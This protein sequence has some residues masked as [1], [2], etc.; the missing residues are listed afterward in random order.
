MPQK[1]CGFVK[2]SEARNQAIEID[3]KEK[4][5]D[6]FTKG[7]YHPQFEYPRQTLMGW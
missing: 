3:T 7:L 1:G 4:F 5:G 2:K 6:V